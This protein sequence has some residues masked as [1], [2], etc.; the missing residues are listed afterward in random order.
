MT[1]RGRMRMTR[2]PLPPLYLQIQF[3]VHARPGI[4]WRRQGW[5]WRPI[6]RWNVMEKRYV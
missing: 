1:T 3:R 2:P 5:A 4:V 6:K